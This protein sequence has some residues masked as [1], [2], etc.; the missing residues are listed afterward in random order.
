MAS[1]ILSQLLTFTLI[2]TLFI[3]TTAINNST[4]IKSLCNS[5]PYPNSCLDSLI[6]IS[7]DP[8]SLLS[9]ILHSLSAAL[10][11]SSSLLPLLLSSHLAEHQRGSVQDCHELHLSTISSLKKSSELLRNST[12]N[13]I[14]G[15]TLS[16]IRTHLSAALTNRNTCLEGLAA[17]TGPRKDALVESWVAAYRHVSNSLSLVSRSGVRGREGK[18]RRLMRRCPAWVKGEER[19]LLEGGDYDGYD[20]ASVS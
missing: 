13:A 8:S 3:P 11:A 5:T 16:D 18:G 20:P 7:I 17:A 4:A 1:S 15:R 9:F 6:S 19:R 12:D 10:S 14:G 2:S